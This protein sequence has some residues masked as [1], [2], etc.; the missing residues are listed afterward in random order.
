MILAAKL[1]LKDYTPTIHHPTA[2]AFGFYT[3]TFLVKQNGKKWLYQLHLFS[4]T[5][6]TK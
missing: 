5:R 1:Q 2:V 6:G 4:S 3:N